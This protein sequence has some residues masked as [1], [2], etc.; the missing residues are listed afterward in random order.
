[1]SKESDSQI[2]LGS[3]LIPLGGFL[4]SFLVFTKIEISF[5]S[6]GL[7]PL[8]IIIFS[9]F[10]HILLKYYIHATK[11]ISVLENELETNRNI[12]EEY[13][14]ELLESN[15]DFNLKIRILN[16]HEYHLDKLLKKRKL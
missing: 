12:L 1:M 5:I 13:K 3:Y 15:I 8:L 10:I 14:D 16:K 4:I 11:Y 2:V 7:A 9:V 6:E